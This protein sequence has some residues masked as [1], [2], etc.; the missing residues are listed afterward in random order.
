VAS[1]EMPGLLTNTVTIQHRWSQWSAR[2][3]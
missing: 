3:F 1:V 2:I